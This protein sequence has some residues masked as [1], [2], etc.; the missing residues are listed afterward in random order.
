M[1]G[2]VL[3]YAGILRASFGIIGGT[4]AAAISDLAVPNHLNALRIDLDGRI[5]QPLP[6][7][8]LLPMHTGRPIL[9]RL[10]ESPKRRADLLGHHRTFGQV[11]SLPI[12]HRLMDQTDA[13]GEGAG[14]VGLLVRREVGAV[15]AAQAD[16][17][18]QDLGRSALSAPGGDVGRRGG[19][20][21]DLPAEVAHPLAQVVGVLRVGEEG[22]SHVRVHAGGGWCSCVRGG[23]ISRRSRSKRLTAIVVMRN[24]GTA[25]ALAR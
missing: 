23:R 9:G 8:G 21:L 1:L 17:A 12:P 14:T 7:A 20:P 25:A 19:E 2:H 24:A 15:D 5:V 13:P 22:G 18:R 6:T 16:G 4:V 10:F 3:A 11:I